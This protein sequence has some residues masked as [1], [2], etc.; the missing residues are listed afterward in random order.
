MCLGDPS[1][2]HSP[3]FSETGRLDL[4]LR[5]RAHTKQETGGTDDYTIHRGLARAD[6]I[7]IYGQV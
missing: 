4:A 6:R 7:T 2:R 5:S 1:R 3:L